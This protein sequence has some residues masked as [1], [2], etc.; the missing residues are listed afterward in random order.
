LVYKT[1]KTQYFPIDINTKSYNL[2]M[3]LNPNYKPVKIDWTKVDSDSDWIPDIEDNCKLDYNPDQL[4]STASGVWDICSDKDNDKMNGNIDNCPIV[5]NPNQEDE[6]KN[7]IWD[8]CETDT[9]L[10]WFFDVI[11]NCPIVYNPDQF[12]S[13]SDWIWDDCDNCVNIYNRDQK[14]LDKDSIWDACD[15]TDDRYIESNR[16]FF[17]WLVI[18]IVTLFLILIAIMFKKLKTLK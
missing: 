17:I 9:D 18:S 4:D 12:D 7:G 1:R 16:N 15:F 6:N 8:V 13:D 14:D 5:Y 10:D 11:D 3:W 2:E